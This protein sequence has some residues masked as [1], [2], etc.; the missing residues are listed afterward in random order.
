MRAGEEYDYFFEVDGELRY[1]FDCDYSSV[2]V[3]EEEATGMGT[4][5]VPYSCGAPMKAMTLFTGQMIIA[6]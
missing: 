2:E 3:L 4:Y 6:N 1:D 5:G